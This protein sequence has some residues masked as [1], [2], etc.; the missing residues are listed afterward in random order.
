MMETIHTYDL[1]E[2]NPKRHVHR[3]CKTKDSFHPTGRER[4]WSPSGFRSE[5]G[6]PQA[7]IVTQL[8]SVD[9]IGHRE[10]SLGNLADIF[11]APLPFDGFQ[12]CL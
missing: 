3:Y 4:N 2:G 1:K 11:E 7:L 6:S 8:N 9:H 5:A 12:V 10:M